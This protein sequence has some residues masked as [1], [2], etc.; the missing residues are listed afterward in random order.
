MALEQKRTA[1]M[2]LTAF[3]VLLLCA[4]G[5]AGYH[6]YQLN[7]ALYAASVS[8]SEA[9]QKIL[10][11]NTNNAE[12]QQALAELT[13]TLETTKS[14]L[15]R[16]LNERVTQ[17]QTEGARAAQL[18]HYLLSDVQFELTQLQQSFGQL[19]VKYVALLQYSE[20]LAQEIAE[21][22]QSASNALL[23]DILLEHIK[24][25]DGRW[26]DQNALSQQVVTSVRALLY[27]EIT[28]LQL[29]P[30]LPLSS[31][32]SSVPEGLDQSALLAER[33]RLIEANQQLVKRLHDYADHL[34]RLYEHNSELE[35]QL[36]S[37]LFRLHR[38]DAMIDISQNSVNDAKSG[39]L[40]N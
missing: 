8:T 21:F 32:T 33:E 1:F 36:L 37:V 17:L 27:E 22:E 12:Q 11:L 16:Q 25:Y 26:Q 20:G 7:Q 13:Q 18:S 5:M 9:E 29:S 30:E 15:T 19:H 40:L 24:T 31:E 3:T 39:F 10:A 4:L 6:I 14:T 23:V 38:S 2:T 34:S 28:Q 35:G